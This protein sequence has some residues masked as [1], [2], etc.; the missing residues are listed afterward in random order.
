MG[1]DEAK[2]LEFKYNREKFP[3]DYIYCCCFLREFPTLV[4]MPEHDQWG[5]VPP[6][7]VGKQLKQSS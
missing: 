2:V 7:T 4:S 1:K 5:M 3:F 6:Q